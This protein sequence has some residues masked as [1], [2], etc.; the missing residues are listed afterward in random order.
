MR[1]PF[2][3]WRQR[4]QAY[5]QTFLR[6]DDGKPDLAGEEVLRDLAKFCC[7]NRTTI[8]IS[9]VSRTIDPL[10]MAVAEGRREV[11]M[12]IAKKLYLSDADI[13]RFLEAD[14]GTQ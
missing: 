8:R 1:T 6:G 14:G 7:A 9:P 3:A 10:A 5:R 11:F 13:A 2:D 12:R 4:R